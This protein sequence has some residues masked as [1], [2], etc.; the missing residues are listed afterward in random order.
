MPEPTRQFEIADKGGF[1]ARVDFCFREAKLVV[2]ADSYKYHSGKLHW[3]ADLE[4][5]NRLTASGYTVLNVTHRQ[6]EQKNPLI[7]EAI[8]RHLA[9]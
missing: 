9:G 4:R 5:R 3:E 8:R 6:I 2:E 1:V 7:V